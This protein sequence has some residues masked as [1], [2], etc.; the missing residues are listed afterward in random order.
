[1]RLC[2]TG[3]SQIKGAVIIPGIIYGS[4]TWTLAKQ[5]DL[6]LRRFE[7]KIIRKICGSIKNE[8]TEQSRIRTNKEL[9]SMYS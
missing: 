7:H 8:M 2:I 3:S 1:M 9:N 4:E 5:N 6:L